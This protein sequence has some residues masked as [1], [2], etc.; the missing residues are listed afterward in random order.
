M[1]CILFIADAVRPDYLGCYGNPRIQTPAIDALASA[2]TRFDQV[3][4]AAPWTAPS[5][6]S[7]ISGIYAHKHQVFTWDKGLPHSIPTLFH[8]FAENRHEVASFV[9]DRD[10]LFSAMP[11]A[12]VQGNTGDMDEVCRW[13]ANNAS[14]E[15]FLLVHSWATHMPYQVQHSDRPAWKDAKRLFIEKLQTGDPAAVRSSQEAY[16][17]SIEYCSSRQVRRLVD[18]LVDQGILDDTL[19]I[20]MSDHGESWGERFE[21][22][23]QI[24]GI[25]HLHGRF[26]YDETI[27]VPLIMH[28]P[29]RLPAGR[30]IGGQV[31]TVDLL[32]TILEFAEIPQP[33]AGYDGDSIRELISGDRAANRAAY[34]ST[35]EHG[36]LSKICL[37]EPPFK[38]IRNLDLGTEELYDLSTDGREKDN[39]FAERTSEA[40]RMKE[41]VDQQLADRDVD[42]LSAEEE[43]LLTQ[44]L[45]DL[46]YI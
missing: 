8:V 22:S 5:T 34:C 36:Q 35:S 13:L 9:F 18:L 30:V 10:Y 11:Y 41:A 37:R 24:E 19:F 40:E 2:G 14:Q 38:Y 45:S 23:G 15:F 1:K 21:D 26:L 44:R 32:P 42:R 16:A 25:H 33:D 43:A 20:F 39:Q 28:W 29:A 4:T 46:G 31:R 12:N 17:R 27:M 7:I 3:V 6:A